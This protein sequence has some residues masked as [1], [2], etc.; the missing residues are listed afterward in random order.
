FKTPTIICNKPANTTAA[1][2]YSMP[3]PAIK[4]IITITVAPAP[5][6]IIP[7]LPPNI[8]VIIPIIKAPYNPVKGGNPATIANDKDSGIMVIATVNP[9]KISVR[10]RFNLSKILSFVQKYFFLKRDK[11]IKHYLYLEQFK[12]ILY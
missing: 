9:A 4:A 7:G 6:E 2:K 5:P 10:Y 12:I 1:K 11:K 8:A 3:C